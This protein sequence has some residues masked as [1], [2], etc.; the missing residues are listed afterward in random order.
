MKPNTYGCAMCTRRFGTLK[1]AHI[2]FGMKHNSA[3]ARE[4]KETKQ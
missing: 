2:H 1:G 4:S 3:Y